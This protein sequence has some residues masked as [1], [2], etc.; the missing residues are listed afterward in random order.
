M[1]F[2]HVFESFVPTEWYF[3]F[4]ILLLFLRRERENNIEWI[5]VFTMYVFYLYSYVIWHVVSILYLPFLQFSTR[6]VICLI[7]ISLFKFTRSFYS[8]FE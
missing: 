7:Q 8:V 2:Y 3:L 4:S 1:I 6:S 5:N